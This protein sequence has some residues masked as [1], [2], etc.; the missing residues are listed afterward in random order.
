MKAAAFPEQ[1]GATLWLAGTKQRLLMD[2]S[3][4]PST[5]EDTYPPLNAVS[6]PAAHVNAVSKVTPRRPAP[7][8]SVAVKVGGVEAA[9]AGIPAFA[10]HASDAAVRLLAAVD[11]PAKLLSSRV[12][13]TTV[14]SEEAAENVTETDTPSADCWTTTLDRLLDSPLAACAPPTMSKRRPLAEEAVS[15]KSSDSDRLES[16]TPPA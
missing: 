14:S 16:A 8:L 12:A 4:M 10:S 15:A 9:A 6:M 13:S 7:V 5:T 3:V 2:R 11:T 1:L